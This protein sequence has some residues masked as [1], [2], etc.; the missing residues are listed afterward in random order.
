M[1]AFGIVALVL[2]IVGIFVPIFGSV[3]IGL[4]GFFSILGAHKGK[5]LSIAAVTINIV[6][7]LILTPSLS[8]AFLDQSGD[9]DIVKLK[10]FFLGLLAI[11]IVA[12][13]SFI[14]T[15]IF[16]NEKKNK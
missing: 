13:F 8:L 11:Q 5:T 12:V 16:C 3:L 7:L 6:N 10:V 4:S 2:S 9:A 14:A 1:K 15:A